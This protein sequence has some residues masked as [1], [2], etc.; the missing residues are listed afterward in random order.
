MLKI[1]A[2]LAILF[3]LSGCVAPQAIHQTVKPVE[4]LQTND[5]CIIENPDV[6]PG[7]LEA[8]LKA[9]RAKGY[10]ITQMP[11]DTPLNGCKV[12]STY[13]A[14]WKWDMATYMAFAHIRVYRDGYQVAEVKYDSSQGGLMPK[15]FIEADKKITEMVEQLFPGAASR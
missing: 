12:I 14:N 7:F 4:G 2:A 1:A 6:R 9:M 13:L 10:R 5:I 15:K 8:Y 11:K 3:T